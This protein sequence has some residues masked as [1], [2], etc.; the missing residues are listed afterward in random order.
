MNNNGSNSPRS[1][2][3]QRTY[4]NRNLI[5]QELETEPPRQITGSPRNF[6]A[7]PINNGDNKAIHS[8][9]VEA[10]TTRDPPFTPRPAQAL[11]LIDPQTIS[12]NS[13]D[14]NS[15]INN[16]GLNSRSV[17]F[18]GS[19]NS[20]SNQAANEKL[21]ENDNS[22][23]NS[24]STQR[25]RNS[26]GFE[27]DPNTKEFVETNGMVEQI[28]REGDDALHRK[29][30][31]VNRPYDQIL[32]YLRNTDFSGW[33][34]EHEDF[35]KEM[36]DK[37][38]ETYKKLQIR[39]KLNGSMASFPEFKGVIGFLIRSIF[40]DVVD[41]DGVTKTNEVFEFYTQE[42]ATDRKTQLEILIHKLIAILTDSR[43]LF[44][45]LTT[46]YTI[47]SMLIILDS[48]RRY[49]KKEKGEEAPKFYHNFRYRSYLDYITISSCPDNIVM[50]TFTNTG[51]TFFIKI[52]C[53]PILVLGVTDQIV[54]ADQYYNSP[55][56][57]WAHDVQHARRQIQETNSYFDRYVKHNLYYNKRSPFDIITPDQYYQY[58]EKFTKDVILPM[59]KFSQGD[60]VEVK[61]Y[62]QMIKLI[63]FEVV[64]EKAWPITSRSMCRCIPLLYDRFPIENLNVHEENG[65][66]VLSTRDDQ[67][68]DPTTLSNLRGKL[69]HGFYDSVT[70]TINA[71]MHPKYRTSLVIARCADFILKRL[72]CDSNPGFN[73]LLKLTIDETN[74]SEFSQVSPIKEEDVPSKDYLKSNGMMDE[75]GKIIY[76]KKELDLLR[77]KDIYHPDDMMALMD[78]MAFP[79]IDQKKDSAIGN[80]E[81]ELN[82]AIEANNSFINSFSVKGDDQIGGRRNNRTIHKNRKYKSNYRTFRH[83][84]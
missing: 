57:F 12:G 66:Q 83:R 68:D 81:T 26:Q 31:R 15:D 11:S 10:Q 43:Y 52:R 75:T 74:A 13:S 30:V 84:R 44:P 50:P 38:Y 58:M 51:S 46:I 9:V 67:F 2:P 61:A 47:E 63:V 18:E 80:I 78:Y 36:Q 54:L 77:S 28:I 37:P 42:N 45:Y 7:E 82:R 14:N 32:D 73:L 20:Q 79:N 19:Q 49:R 41:E 60:S 33:I 22:S 34:K 59:I 62:K 69:R 24:N 56:D 21:L 64:H 27:I 25:S 8:F 65:Q 48:Y 35:I 17:S 3:L 29:N 70:D 71:V 1:H 5:I 55:I 76:T 4:G 39:L 23:V 72:N 40:Q 6:L 53:V 16:S